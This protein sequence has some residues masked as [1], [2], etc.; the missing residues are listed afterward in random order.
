MNRL[1]KKKSRAHRVGVHV[2]PAIDHA[3]KWDIYVESETLLGPRGL[4]WSKRKAVHLAHTISI[5]KRFSLEVMIN[6]A[7]N[8]LESKKGNVIGQHCDKTCSGC[9]FDFYSEESEQIQNYGCLPTPHDIVVMR[10]EH[11]KTWACHS[12]PTK[13]CTGAIGYLKEQGKPYKVVDP[14]LLT[15][16]SDW[17]LFCA[18]P[19]VLTA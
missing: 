18:T 3:G 14:E 6:D 11:N 16:K 8:H 4:Q 17:H 5:S 19:A 7:V 13:P 1:Q 12:E 9:P 15:E 10:V 2:I